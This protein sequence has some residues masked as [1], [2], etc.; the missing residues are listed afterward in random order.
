MMMIKI[1]VI[2]ILLLFRE[3]ELKGE[4]IKIIKRLRHDFIYI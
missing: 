3:D 1:M 4:G 2:A